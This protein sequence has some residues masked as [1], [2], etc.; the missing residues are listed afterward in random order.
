MEVTAPEKITE[1]HN[2]AAFDSGQETLDS[3]LK[4]KALKNAKNK[5]TVTYVVC[6]PGTPDVVGYFALS[7][8]EV[9]R[10]GSPKHMQRN[11]LNQIPGAVLG[12]LAVDRRYQ[13]Y[14]L[15]SALLA[16]A[17][18]RSLS[19]AEII[20]IRALLV[21]ALDEGAA[22]FYRKHGFLPHQ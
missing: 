10:E 5:A 18:E 22:A 21:H 19:A 13:G 3:C 15:G 2:T 16:K 20:G 8:G 12:R 1:A 7:S 11:M 4:T 9:L 6:K 14:G 17:I